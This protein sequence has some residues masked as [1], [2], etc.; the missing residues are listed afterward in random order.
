L[1]NENL[2][3]D[4]HIIKFTIQNKMNPI[5]IIL[6]VLAGI[7]G[8]VLLIGLFMKKE[9]YVKRSIV[10]NAPREKVFDF[11]RLLKNQEK[12]NQWAKTDPG[13][14]EEFKGTDGTVGHIY[15]WRGNKKAGE[16]QK[17]IKNIIEGKKI[18]TE[19][20][21]VKPMAV[22]AA[23]IMETESLTADQTKVYF[24]NTGTLKYP[25]NVMI[26]VF[27][28]NFAKALDTSLS[29]LKDILEK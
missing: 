26:P 5:I 11:L 17:E 24:T 7:I 14:V 9:H 27:E 19:I 29:T 20:R 13:R 18:E 16:G 6:L 12:F 22:T 10:I 25:L 1:N 23:M 21:F 3:K 4:G 28:K 2:S 8:L 15:S